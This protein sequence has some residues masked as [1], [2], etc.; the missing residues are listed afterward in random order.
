[1]LKNTRRM[2]RKDEGGSSKIDFSKD[3]ISPKYHLTYNK[4]AE[5]EA[6]NPK[7]MSGSYRSEWNSGTANDSMIARTGPEMYRSRTGMNTGIFQFFPVPTIRF[8]SRRSWFPCKS[9]RAPWRH[10]RKRRRGVEETYRIE[11]EVKEP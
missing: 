11:S 7:I 8:R 4:I 2:E 1:M 5:I 9:A 3:R 6:M 10:R